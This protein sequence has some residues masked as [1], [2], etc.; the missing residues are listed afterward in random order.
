MFK[1]FGLGL[2]IHQ[3]DRRRTAEAG[4]ERSSI[5]FHKAPF[6]WLRKNSLLPGAVQPI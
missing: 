2:V 1:R 3:A 5:N 6:R 4:Y